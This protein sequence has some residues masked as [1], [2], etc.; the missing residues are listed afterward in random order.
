M[1]SQTILNLACYSAQLD[2]YGVDKEIYGYGGLADAQV[3]ALATLTYLYASQGMT[4]ALSFVMQA[5]LR[6]EA[7]QN[8][9]AQPAYLAVLPISEAIEIDGVDH[10][11]WA[12]ITTSELFFSVAQTNELI[13][14]IEAR[15]IPVLNKVVLVPVWKAPDRY[16]FAGI[17]G[18]KWS[19]KNFDDKKPKLF[20]SDLTSAVQSAFGFLGVPLIG[21][22]GFVDYLLSAELYEEGYFYT[23]VTMLGLLIA[24]GITIPIGLLGSAIVAMVNTALSYTPV[25][26]DVI[27]YL[28]ATDEWTASVAAL[29]NLLGSGTI[30]MAAITTLLFAPASPLNSPSVPTP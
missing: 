1:R 4:L 25:V 18:N 14:T 16:D 27:D 13:L 7:L 3:A 19:A 21:D 28:I 15:F 5:L 29:L 8:G 24:V 23:G 12:K 30:I 20:N 11:L 2:Q 10:Y 26:Q 6:L 9:L 22:P 17:I